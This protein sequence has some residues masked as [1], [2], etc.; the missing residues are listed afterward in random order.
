MRLSFLALA[1]V[2]VL[3]L[4]SCSSEQPV[5]RDDTEAR[6]KILQPGRPGEPNETLDPDATVEEPGA[7]DA[8]IAFMQM[9]VP[10]HAQ[11]LE[12]SELAQT[13]ASDEQ[14]VSLS[15]RIKGA[16]GPEIVSMSSWLQSRDLAVPESMADAGGV[17]DHSGH[18]D[19]SRH[20]EDQGGEVTA[21][22]MG[23]LSDARM[24]EL[25]RA[26]GARFDRLFL[27]GMIRHHQGA[28]DMALD[29]MDAGTDTL[30]LE[31]AADVAAGQQAEIRRMVDIRR[32]L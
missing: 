1:T 7:S 9:M 12:M 23:M 28:V 24:T 2:L 5:E 32:R 13:R 19:H 26:R 25:A 14:V 20:G 16:Q 6:S 18:S 10:H 29:E 21:T 15:R 8:D 22:A 3:A 11:A 30:A 17:T 31:L 4:A 27:S